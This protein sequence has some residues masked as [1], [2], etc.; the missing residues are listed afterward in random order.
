MPFAD[1]IENRP[2]V[3]PSIALR[4]GITGVVIIVAGLILGTLH[5]DYPTH[6]DLQPAPPTVISGIVSATSFSLPT[7][8]TAKFTVYD[9]RQ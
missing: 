8:S 9:L 2:V 3:R 6:V 5:P 1:C 7:G 4:A